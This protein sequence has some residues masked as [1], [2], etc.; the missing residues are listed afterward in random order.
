M[1]PTTQL[2]GVR[3]PPV[4]NVS[5][6]LAVL[7]IITSVVWKLLGDTGINLWL[8]PGDVWSGQVL[9]VYYGLFW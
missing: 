8:V 1:R 2:G 5:T 9:S 7:I 6:A 4:R 3:L